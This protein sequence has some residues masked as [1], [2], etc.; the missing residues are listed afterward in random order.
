LHKTENT[1]PSILGWL[2][3]LKFGPCCDTARHA[4]VVAAGQKG[5][6]PSRT[7]AG[8]ARLGPAHLRKFAS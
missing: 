3:I 4:E 2:T 5:S 8:V 7:D 6:P 1:E